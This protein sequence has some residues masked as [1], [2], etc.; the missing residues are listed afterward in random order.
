MQVALE[1]HLQSPQLSYPQEGH[2][3]LAVRNLPLSVFFITLLEDE[4]LLKKH[5]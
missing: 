5:L 1:M 2:L 3:I 4:A